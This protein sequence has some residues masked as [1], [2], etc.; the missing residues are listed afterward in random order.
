MLKESLGLSKDNK[1]LNLGLDNPNEEEILEFVKMIG[2]D[3]NII[4]NN[5]AN[6][7]YG[8]AAMT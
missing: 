5:I 6:V 4:F 2:E 1:S 7:R 3:I 8:Q